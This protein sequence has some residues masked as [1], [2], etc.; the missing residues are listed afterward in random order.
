MARTWRREFRPEHAFVRIKMEG[1]Q[2]AENPTQEYKQ[3]LRPAQQE[4]ESD[5]VV[6]HRELFFPLIPGF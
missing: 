1:L 5:K 6:L 2:R 4:E 3:D